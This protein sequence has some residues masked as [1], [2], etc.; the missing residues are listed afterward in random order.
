MR[1]FFDENMPR[2]FGKLLEP[3]EVS[4][5]ERMGWKGKKNGE[6][7]RL[8]EERFDVMM[9][10]DQ[11]LAFQTNFVGRNL[12]LI[13]LPT[14]RLILLRANAIAVRVTLD[15]LSAFDHHAIITIDWR[16]RRKM[17]RLDQPGEFEIEL[18]QVA[19][20]PSR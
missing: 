3:H 2:Q 1:V 7:L 8:V 13:V 17:R 18:T 16:G 14:Q 15:E 9:T 10:S 5:V 20:F 19:A 4:N 11:A 6:L 12:S